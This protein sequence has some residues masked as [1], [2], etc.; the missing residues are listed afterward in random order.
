[1]LTIYGRNSRFC[2]GISR[3]SFIKIGGFAFGGVA[4]GLPEILRAQAA[5]GTNPSHHKAIINIFLAGGPPHQ[6]MWDV[7]TEAPAD[8]RG[9]FKPIKTNVSGIEICEE[10]PRIAKI[11]DK[12]AVIRSV[13]GSD[14]GHD[15]YQITTGYS[16]RLA[17]KVGGYPALGCVAGKVLGPIHSAVPP[18]VA[19]A[20]PTRHRPWSEPGS[21]GYLGPTASAFQPFTTSN[22]GVD[23]GSDGGINELRLKNISLD[24]LRDRQ[25]LLKSVD[26]LRR[27]LDNSEGVQ[28][29]DAAF[30]SAFDMLASSKIADALDVSKED[31]KIRERYGDGKPY[32]FQYDGAPT[33]NDHLLMARRLVEVGCRSVTLSFGRWDSH[34]QNFALVRDHGR[35]LDQCFS[36]LVEDLDQRGMLDDVTVIAWGE[37]G[38][39]P[40]V[41][42]GAG[43]D[44]WPRVSCAIMAGGG[45]Q[46]GQ[47][48]GS[49]DVRGGSADERP[50]HIQEIMATLYHNIGIDTE[51]VKL[52]DKS[53]RPQYL[54]DQAYRR[55]MPELVG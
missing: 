24:R 49:T 16:R 26:S 11:M 46:G 51:T 12:C 34:G 8:V 14:G 30:Q 23:R 10:F 45:I 6:D 52:F 27:D 50:V 37:F 21:P 35:K 39:T 55:P 48:I 3:R 32:K 13:V 1:M 15:G 22:Q 18:A 44:H 20:A 9:E 33:C 28:A 53:T 31:P 7:K 29:Q 43:R 47:A 17:M 25:R 40:K 4:L 42:K 2:D 54:L 36:A 19:L 41:N 38:R 5:S